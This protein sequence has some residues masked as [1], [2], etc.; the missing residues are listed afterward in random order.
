MIPARHNCMDICNLYNY[1]ISTYTGGNPTKNVCVE[2]SAETALKLK[3]NALHNV[4]L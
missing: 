1:G 4:N 2:D 3:N